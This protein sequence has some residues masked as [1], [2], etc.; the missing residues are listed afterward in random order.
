M[1]I[2]PETRLT[3]LLGHPVSHSVSPAIHNES[4]RRLGLNAVYLAFDVKNLSRAVEGLKEL[5]AVGCNVTIPHKEE[6]RGLVDLLSEEAEQVGAVNTIKFGDDL[7]GYNTDVHGV[8]HTL[9][10][11]GVGEIDRALILG[12]G[13]AA[14]SVLVGIAGRARLV[15]V[16]SRNIRGARG[17]LEL[18]GGVGLDALAIPWGERDLYLG[19]VDLLI[20]ATP[21]GTLGEGVPVD[22]RRLRPGC[23]VFDLVYNPPVTTLVREAVRRGCRALGGL[24]MLVRQAAEAER[25][26]FG[27]EP[28][29]EAM[30]RAAERA[31]GVKDE[32]G[33][34]G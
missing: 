4:Y 7:V 26:W 33:G 22:P 19:E 6:A 18:C 31:L 25:I 23:Y 3:C 20:N 27:V 28:D 34:E 17:I 16:T 9:E 8:S 21:V 29:E 2:D 14:R 15:Y 30:M 11:L 5:G 32:G 13:G 10:L 24:P 12:A 1:W